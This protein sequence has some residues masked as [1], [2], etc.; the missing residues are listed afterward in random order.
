MNK[1]LFIFLAFLSFSAFA[2]HNDKQKIG[3]SKSVDNYLKVVIKV[4]EVPGLAVGIIK[5]NK[6]I[7]QQYYGIGIIEDDKKVDSNSLFR[8][9]STTKLISTVCI[10]QL[11]EKGQLSLEDKISKH[12]NNLPTEWQD[13]KIKNLLSHSS[14][15]PDIVR[16][17]DISVNATNS[18]VIE[19]LSKEK[20][21]FQTGDH[22]SY[23]QTN[24]LL[25]TMIIEKI[26]GQT[27]E[28]FV[29]ENQFSNSQ[30]EV[31]FSSNSNER[32]PNRVQKYNYN[33][34]K[35]QY[36]KSTHIGG[37]RAHS[38]N[39]IAIT[40]PA[41]LQWSI[42]LN[43]NVFLKENTKKMMWKLFPFN[44]KQDIF[45]YG[46]EVNNMNNILSAG[47]SGGNVSAY[48]IF[49]DNNVSIILMY[50]GYKYP[51][52]PIQYQ[53]INHIAQ[54]IDP[55]L[56]D[57]FLLS[58]EANN[59]D[60]V[61][62][63]KITKENYGYRI[64]K[65]KVIFSYKQNKN[66]NP[67]FIKSISVAGSFNDWNPD[68][69]SFQMIKK[70]GNAFELSV[71]K[72]QFEKGKIYTFKFVMNKINWLTTPYKAKNIDGTPDNNLTL[73]ID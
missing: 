54:L 29:L 26:S 20:M 11:I 70:D 56:A 59:K 4:N 36:E 46:W 45:G 18:E 22:Y 47:F 39:G 53:V 16:F 37:L 65:D 33:E 48:K 35:K 8:I 40:L 52:F 27:F 73:K 25:L 14:G 50:N 51:S 7:F 6:I 12:I 2:Q 38:A 32:I 71:P 34:T 69:Q 24:F 62:Q 68:N 72:S 31:L 17:D 57:P 9:Y 63:P 64:E 30:N 1:V 61:T 67:Q 23:N 55:K 41:F 5:N 58:E 44:N 3:I 15:I 28:D 19:R 43:K 49:P 42:N 13:V 10:F 21:E 60:I 66:Q